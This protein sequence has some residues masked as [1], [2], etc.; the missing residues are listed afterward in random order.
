M[1]EPARSTMGIVASK[2]FR[3]SRSRFALIGQVWR[4][5]MGKRSMLSPSQRQQSVGLACRI[6]V[7]QP[8]RELLLIEAL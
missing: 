6:E 4:R 8:S 5:G 2:S 1:N 3:S 7:I